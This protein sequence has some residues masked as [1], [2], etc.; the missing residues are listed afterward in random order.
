MCCGFRSIKSILVVRFASVIAMLQTKFGNDDLGARV[1]ILLSK[2]VYTFHKVALFS[3]S[4]FI[5]RQSR[6]ILW[7][8]RD[9]KLLGH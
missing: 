1:T 9:I 3:V 5:K 6:L 2:V 4:F 8:S 7:R